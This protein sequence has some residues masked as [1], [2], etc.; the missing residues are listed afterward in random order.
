MYLQKFGGD[1]PPHPYLFRH[2]YMLKKDF[3]CEVAILIF[4]DLAKAAEL[5]R[6]CSY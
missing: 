2:P 1:Q 4:R 5:A 6:S 3:S